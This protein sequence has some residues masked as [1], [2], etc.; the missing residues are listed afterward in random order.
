[1]LEYKGER[2]QIRSNGVVLCCDQRIGRLKKWEHD[3][4]NMWHL[5]N[6]DT[7]HFPLYDDV[8]ATIAEKQSI[9]EIGEYLD[10][11]LKEFCEQSGLTS[12]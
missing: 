4:R 6:A 9:Q 10:S 11:R 3:D 7:K 8:Q 2:V 1:M 5:E 12:V